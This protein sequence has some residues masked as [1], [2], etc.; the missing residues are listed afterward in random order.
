M[1]K[2]LKDNPFVVRQY[3][4][5]E[6]QQL[7]TREGYIGSLKTMQATGPKQ[8]E[9]LELWDIDF[10]DNVLEVINVKNLK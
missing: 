9:F 8:W 3:R 7:Y 1:K 10:E 4:V 2:T 6:G 5:R